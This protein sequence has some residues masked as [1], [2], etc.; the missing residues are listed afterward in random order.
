M[1][2]GDFLA[3]LFLALILSS[4]LTWGFGWRH[5]ARSEPVGASVVFVFLVLGL[6]MWAFGAWIPPVGPIWF[7]TAFVDLLLI[8]LFIS[9]L[10]LALAGPRRLPK[11]REEAVAEV[12]ESET[13]AVVFGTFFWLFV[14]GLV[15]AGIASYFW[16]P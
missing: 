12:R 11:T 14:L 1:I 10:I 2:I 3:V 7:G 15:I 16:N 6:G 13:A 5:P 9:L 4:L 8:G